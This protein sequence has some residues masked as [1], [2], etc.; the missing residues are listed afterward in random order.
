MPHAPIS[1]AELVEQATT[2]AFHPGRP[3]RTRSAAWWQW[4][5]RYLASPEWAARREATLDRDAYQC[6]RCRSPADQV[7]HLRYTRVGFESPGDLIS[8][9]DDCHQAVHAGVR[10]VELRA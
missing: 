5:A 6:R 7:H 9:C 8:L 3:P 10:F 4:Y 1:I 2:R